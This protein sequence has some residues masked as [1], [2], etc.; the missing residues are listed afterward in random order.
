MPRRRIGDLPL[1]GGGRLRDAEIAYETWGTPGAEAV[2]VCHALT[3]DQRAGDIGGHEGWWRGIVGPGRVLDTDHSFVVASNVIGSCYGSTGPGAD[4]LL[5]DGS[6]LPALSVQDMVQAQERLLAALG[7]ERLRL[8]VGGSLGGLQALAWAGERSVPAAHVIAIGAGDRLPALQV[9][10]C[11]AQHVALELGLRHGDAAGGLRAARAIAMTTYRSDPHFESRFGR[12]PA[13][14]GLRRFAVESYLD[15]HGDRLADRFNA[16]S[17]LALSQ[18]MA[19]FAWDL[20]VRAG[21]RVD[22]VAIEH[23]WLFPEAAVR[24]LHERLVRRDVPG[25]YRVLPTGMGH[26]A[27]LAE[28]EALGDILRG[29]LDARASGAAGRAA[30][31]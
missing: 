24:G 8:V 27:F 1:A 22:L 31:G 11:H 2:L 21:T 7:V 19:A 28:Q 13:P 30:L 17:Y 12:S 20:A 16:W 29:L 9:A 25:A 3:G 23:D 15:H 6:P 14:G 10:L 18:A 4:G 26:D 5:P